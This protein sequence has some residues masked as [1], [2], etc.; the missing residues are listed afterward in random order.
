MT[1][2][3]LVSLI[4][5]VLVGV[6]GYTQG[7]IRGLVRLLALAAGGILGALFVLWLGSLETARATVG[8][9]TV[10]ALLSL[11]ACAA[12]AWGVSKAVPKVTH[13]R[14][15]NRVLGV[16]PALAI[17]LLVL[18]IGLGLADRV[19]M[20][21]ATQALIRRGMLTGPLVA[22]TDLLEQIVAGVR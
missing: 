10:G 2:L 20:S 7:L 14:L 8:W 9:A 19:A 13:R 17:G 3:D 11:A 22:V 6:G 18:A 16:V 21:P 4:F 1:W 12:L 15:S 5:L